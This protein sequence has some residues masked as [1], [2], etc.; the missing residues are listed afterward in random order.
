MIQS[1]GVSF[2]AAFVECDLENTVAASPLVVI[3]PVDPALDSQYLAFFLNSAGTQEFLRREAIGTYVPQLKRGV[4]AQL[5][6]PLPA[7]R[8]QRRIVNAHRLAILER[9]LNV[10]LADLRS[11]RLRQI[12][13]ALASTENRGGSSRITE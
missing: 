1:R 12:A 7:V 2:P 3:R 11:S 8:D 13:F 4:F 10:R 5:M 9:D 6:I